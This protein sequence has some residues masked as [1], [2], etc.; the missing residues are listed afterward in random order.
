MTT[1]TGVGDGDAAPLGQALDQRLVDTLLQAL[2]VRG[3]D[4]E[5]AAV[6]L[7]LFDG[8]CIGLHIRPP[9]Q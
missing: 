4:Q 6:G 3:V 7:E 8:F 9:D 5:L 2:V 1:A